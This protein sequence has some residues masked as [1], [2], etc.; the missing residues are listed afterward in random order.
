[1]EDISKT[2]M[3]MVESWQEVLSNNT[4]LSKRVKDLKEEKEILIVTMEEAIA[5]KGEK[6]KRME[7]KLEECGAVTKFNRCNEQLTYL[8]SMERWFCKNVGL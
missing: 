7:D 3:Q 5:K 8:L 2:Y 4:A 1:M 6:I